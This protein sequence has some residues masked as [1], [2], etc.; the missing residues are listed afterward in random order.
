MLVVRVLESQRDIGGGFAHLPYG[1]KLPA[2]S[3]G[4]APHPHAVILEAAERF[5][6]RILRCLRV[7]GEADGRCQGWGCDGR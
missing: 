5:N 1:V 7:I 3:P 4:A 6:T 2:L